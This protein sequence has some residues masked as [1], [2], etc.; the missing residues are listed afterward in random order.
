MERDKDE[1]LWWPTFTFAKW[2]RDERFDTVLTDIQRELDVD[3]YQAWMLLLG[4]LQTSCDIMTAENPPDKE[5][6]QRDDEDDDD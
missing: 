4:M 3:R 5:P 1:P 6:W 2:N